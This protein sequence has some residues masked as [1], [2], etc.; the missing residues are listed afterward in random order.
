[1]LLLSAIVASAPSPGA[2]V[3]AVFAVYQGAEPSFENDCPLGPSS[4]SSARRM[5]AMA[6]TSTGCVPVLSF[7]SVFVNPGL[8]EFTLIFVSRS[9]YAR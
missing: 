9:S 3:A 8:A 1:M 2:E 4:S 5:A 7:R 6:P